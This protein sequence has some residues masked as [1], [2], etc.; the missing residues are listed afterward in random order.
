MTAPF[1]VGDRIAIVTGG[2]GQ[3]G[4]QFSKSLAQAGAKAAVHS[5]RPF[6]A[7]QVAE[8]FPGLETSIRVYEASV[9]DKASPMAA[10]DR[11]IADWSVPH[12]LVN[13]A[14]IDS[15]ADGGAEQNA[16]FEGYPQKFWNEIIDLNPSGVMLAPQVVGTKMAEAG[17]GAIIN[18]SSIYGMISA[19]PGALRL[20]P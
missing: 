10:T 7:D 16:P 18:I 14:G 2:L 15:E 8:R 17:R 9:T 4:S 5:R 12:I 20:P 3:L 13:K 11:L 1:S 19:Q 6:S